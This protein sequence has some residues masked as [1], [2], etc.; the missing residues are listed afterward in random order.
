MNAATPILEIAGALPDSA[1]SRIPGVPLYL[2]IMPG[3]FALIDIPDPQLAAEFA[4]LCCGLLRIR[5]GSVRFLGRDWAGVPDELAAAMRGR[6][7][8]MYGPGSWVGFLGTDVN[9]LLSQLH[10][11]RRTEAGLRDAAAELSYRFGLPGLPLA[12]PAAVSAADLLRA[13]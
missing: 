6:I 2:R 5:Q 11:T 3:D 7:G 12:P 13:A 8:R 9:I 10:H 1:E 4:D